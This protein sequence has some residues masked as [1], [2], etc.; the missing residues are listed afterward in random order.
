M[1]QHETTHKIGQPVKTAGRPHGFGI[2]RAL[3]FRGFP[4]VDSWQ[5]SHGG[6][7]G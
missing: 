7:N 5:A 2:V 4:S 6:S 1:S 3:H